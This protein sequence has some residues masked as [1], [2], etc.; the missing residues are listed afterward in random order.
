M[1]YKFQGC[2]LILLQCCVIG[3]HALILVDKPQFRNCPAE[4]MARLHE[5]V[6]VT[7]IVDADPPADTAHFY[8]YLPKDPLHNE[9]EYYVENYDSNV[10]LTP[11][12]NK[13]IVGNHPEAKWD[14][15]GSYYGIVYNVCA[16]AGSKT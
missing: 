14:R 2:E 7:C 15:V 11:V 4:K 5:H 3:L 6:N 16:P 8:W 10:T 13:P 12:P 1:T 9:K